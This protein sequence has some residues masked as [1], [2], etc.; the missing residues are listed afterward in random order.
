MHVKAHT[1]GAIGIRP[2]SQAVRKGKFTCMR[3]GMP[4]GRPKNYLESNPTGALCK[5]CDALRDPLISAWRNQ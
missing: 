1:L 3:C 2:D 4:I 5:D